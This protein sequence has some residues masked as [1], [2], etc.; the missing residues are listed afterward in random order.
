MVTP[1]PYENQQRMSIIDG[2]RDSLAQDS[3]FEGNS[4]K[5]TALHAKSHR[6]LETLRNVKNKT[7]LNSSKSTEADMKVRGIKKKSEMLNSL[8]QTPTIST[9]QISQEEHASLKKAHSNLLVARDFGSVL[10]NYP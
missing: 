5:K 6:T 8:F 3:L 7:Y 4:A 9:N 2:D 1:G 10:A